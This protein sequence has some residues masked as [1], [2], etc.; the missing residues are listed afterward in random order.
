MRKT[1]VLI[2]DDSALIR[3]LL[4][5]IIAGAADFEVA[6]TA[7]DPYEAWRKIKELDPDVVTLDV[8]MPRMD[9]LSF[10]ERL[11][12]LHPMP[13]LMVSS[14]TENGCTT[15]LRALELGAVDFVSKPRVDLH[16]GVLELA[17]EL[18][19][20]LRIVAGAK[21]NTCCRRP[22]STP[23]YQHD[24]RPMLKT[25]MRIVAI[26]ASTGGTEALK[27]VLMQL[28]PDSPP[29]A[30]VQ[31]MPPGFTRAFAARLNSLCSVRVRE[32]NDGDRLMA[33]HVLIAPGDFHMALTRSGTS[34][35]V[36]V[37]AGKP[38]NRHRP[39][40]DV[41]FDSVAE[42]AGAN[43]VGVLL[44]GMG[45]DGAAGLKRMHDGSATTLVQDEQTCV[46]YGMPK[47]AVELGAVDHVLPLPQIAGR[48]L[49]A[50]AR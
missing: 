30:I 35:G 10:L 32:A 12:H 26:G 22:K 37:F 24:S 36:R 17:D 18:M 20:K 42:H 31:H 41:L 11:M 2:V 14:L 38:V 44:T 5:E 6:G 23:L 43:A 48:I 29:V 3:G 8:E 40:V 45:S 1:R 19:Q 47:E 16:A 39:S 4:K 13:V 34:Y 46:V 33:G 9:G 27:D 7:S 21:V 25:T 28:P 15:T 50:C 49:A